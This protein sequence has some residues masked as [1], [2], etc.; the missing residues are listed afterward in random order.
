[1]STGTVLQMDGSQDASPH[2]AMSGSADFSK[3]F[4]PESLAQ[5][6]GLSFL[7][8]PEKVVLSQIRGHAYAGGLG[9]VEAFLLPAM[10]KHARDALQSEAP[11][12]DVPQLMEQPKEFDEM[13]L[14][15]RAEFERAFET[16]CRLI[17][18]AEDFTQNVQRRHPLASALTV[19]HLSSLA[20]Q[21]Y[22]AAVARD[23]RIDPWFK[24]VLSARW[25]V[26]KAQSAE[27]MRVAELLA[28]QCDEAEIAEIFEEYL[29]LAM[30]LDEVFAGQ[31]ELDLEA[32]AGAIGRHFS[33]AEQAEFRSIQIRANR[34]TFVGS[35]MAHAEFLDVVENISPR[36]R[37]RIET[38]G[39]AFR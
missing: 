1:M 37:R 28:A 8:T 16:K 15:F 13:L 31:V 21:H 7:S 10:R 33:D 36:A 12:N 3:P 9:L 6:A 29:E 26:K 25:Q 11:A 22:L 20:Q 35:A 38:I 27:D 30:Y 2:A 23:A 39:A 18:Q 19:L 4:L 14:V 24:E 32:L 34:W 5:T 17:G